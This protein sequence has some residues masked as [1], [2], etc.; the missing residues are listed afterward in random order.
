MRE[1]N[2][3]AHDEDARLH[4]GKLDVMRAHFAADPFDGAPGGPPSHID[5]DMRYALGVKPPQT[6]YPFDWLNLVVLPI[7]GAGL[8]FA[9]WRYGWLSFDVLKEIVLHD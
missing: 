2:T 5:D 3:G 4:I 6:K 8:L 7:I 1:P 9:T